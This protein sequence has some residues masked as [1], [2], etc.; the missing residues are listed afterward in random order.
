MI[1]HVMCFRKGG[2]DFQSMKIHP[3]LFSIVNSRSTDLEGTGL[4]LYTVYKNVG[5]FQSFIGE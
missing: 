2:P 5:R 4:E 3:L 1:Y